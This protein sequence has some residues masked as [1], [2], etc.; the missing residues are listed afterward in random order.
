MITE[1]CFNNDEHLTQFSAF[2]FFPRSFEKETSLYILRLS[3]FFIA[4]LKV[5][6][7]KFILIIAF[8][9]I[10]PWIY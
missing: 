5:Q 1:F 7:V 6:G 3:H 9:K 2:E 10:N 4:S 8:N